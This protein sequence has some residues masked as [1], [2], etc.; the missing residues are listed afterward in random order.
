MTSRHSKL[1]M[2]SGNDD[3]L[4]L[5]EEVKE[6]VKKKRTI[7]TPVPV[8][9]ESAGLTGKQLSVCHICF[10]K[11]NR[12]LIAFTNKSHTQERGCILF[13]LL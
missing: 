12:R 9:T 2:I 4:I 3:A 5:Q 1:C 11:I 6:V 13:L 10:K 8:Q 7:R